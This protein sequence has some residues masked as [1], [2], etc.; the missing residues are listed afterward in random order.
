[1]GRRRR[2]WVSQE[3]GS[4]HIISRTTGADILFFDQEKEYFMNLLEG[5]AAGFFVQIHAFAILGNHFHILAT[6]M[7]LDA[8]NASEKELLRRYRSRVLRK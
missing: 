6:G 8:Q 7:E 3:V 2:Q 4:F 5:L 1:M